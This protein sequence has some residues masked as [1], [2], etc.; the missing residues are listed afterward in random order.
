[1]WLIFL[2]YI[3]A[4]EHI[5][6]EETVFVISAHKGWEGGKML[7]TMF[8][9][10]LPRAQHHHH[11]MQWMLQTNGEFKIVNF[12]ATF[13]ERFFRFIYYSVRLLR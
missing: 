8:P 3:S 11:H 1:M 12:A 4:W 2:Q 13:Q 7:L 6:E 9:I 10:Y 5:A